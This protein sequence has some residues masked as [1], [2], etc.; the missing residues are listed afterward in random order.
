MI[1]KRK[2]TNRELHPLFFVLT[3]AYAI[4][5]INKLWETLDRSAVNTRLI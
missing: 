5:P 4:S 2:A 1:E 3:K